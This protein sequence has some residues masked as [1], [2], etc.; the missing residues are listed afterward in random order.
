MSTRTVAS[1]SRQMSAGTTYN[2]IMEAY[3]L[4][5]TSEEIE[6]IGKEKFKS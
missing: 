4:G 1:V 2:Q 5:W 6:K 3:T